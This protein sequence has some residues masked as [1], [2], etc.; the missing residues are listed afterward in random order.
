M[1]SLTTKA[2][3]DMCYSKR[4]MP[5]KCKML[6]GFA[7]SKEV[8][9]ITI[10]TG[11]TAAPYRNFTVPGKSRESESNISETNTHTH[12]GKY[13]AFKESQDRLPSTLLLGTGTS[14][15]CHLC[16]VFHQHC[17]SHSCRALVTRGKLLFLHNTKV[18]NH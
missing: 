1:Q 13:C 5:E 2:C 18:Q 15:C 11:F 16:Q 8:V 6:A 14:S 10:S 12:P 9:L 4:K 17:L 3:V 7:I